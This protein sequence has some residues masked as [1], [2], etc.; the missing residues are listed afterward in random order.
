MRL[1]TTCSTPSCGG[2]V[3]AT[4]PMNWQPSTS[5]NRARWNE[6]DADDQYTWDHAGSTSSTRWM[7]QI[8]SM[9][10]DQCNGTSDQRG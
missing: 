6:V 2:M 1:T 8:A 4:Q 5:S 9:C 10:W 7:Y 3:R